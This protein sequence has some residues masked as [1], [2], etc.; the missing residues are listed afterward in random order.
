[1]QLEAGNVIFCTRKLETKYIHSICEEVKPYL[2]VKIQECE[3]FKPQKQHV[4]FLNVLKY[5][6]SLVYIFVM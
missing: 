2:F 5:K 4:P 1:M 3:I 6:Q